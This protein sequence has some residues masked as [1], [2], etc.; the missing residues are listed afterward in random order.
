MKK[1]SYV[2]WLLAALWLAFILDARTAQLGAAEGIKLCVQAAIPSLFPFFFLSNLT[3][4][5]FSGDDF[6]LLSNS[7]I[8][9]SILLPAILGG[10]PMGSSAVAALYQDKRLTKSQA[11]KLLIFNQPGPA[12]VFGIVS[13]AFPKVQTVFMLWGIILFSAML[14]AAIIHPSPV[15]DTPAKSQISLQSAIQSSLQGMG[16][17]CSWILLF[18]IIIEYL[19]KWAYP[20]CPILVQIILTGSLELTNGCLC[21]KLVKNESIRFILCAGML[22]FGGICVTMQ[23]ASVSSPLS[24][25]LY[26]E[27]KI[28]QTFLAVMLS[29][30]VFYSSFRLPIIILC[31][32]I[33]LLRVDFF[34]HS[35]YN[36]PNKKEVTPCCFVKK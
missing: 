7:P 10:Y 19:K 4:S 1:S 28:L 29:C 33:F 11:E 34:K 36:K 6:R 9:K 21:L 12:F 32:G 27:A 13:R 17:V 24:I 18:R 15:P 14:T 16:K 25:R 20:H 23:T 5:A 35:R 26:C 30:A 8:P 31:S 22:A 3:L 2:P